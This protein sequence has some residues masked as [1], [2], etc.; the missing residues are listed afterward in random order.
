MQSVDVYICP[1]YNIFL[2]CNM[3]PNIMHILFSDGK[4]PRRRKKSC[5]GIQVNTRALGSLWVGARAVCHVWEL[6]TTHWGQL[7]LVCWHQGRTTGLN[8]HVGSEAVQ[9]GPVHW[10]WGYTPCPTLD[11]SLGPV[12]WPV[13]SPGPR[14]G[15]GVLCLVKGSMLDWSWCTRSCCGPALHMPSQSS[16]L[17]GRG[18][19]HGSR[20]LDGTG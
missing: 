19:P 2:A 14:T 1:Y 15:S 11:S 4:T 3:P 8:L 7:D 6:G 12:H 13:H 18:A 10:F 17:L 5:F 9:W 20:D 16:E